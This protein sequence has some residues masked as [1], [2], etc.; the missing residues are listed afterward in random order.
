MGI[1]QKVQQGI[2]VGLGNSTTP[3]GSE[4]I[5]SSKTL[6]MDVHFRIIHNRQKVQQHNVHQLYI[7][8]MWSIHKIQYYSAIKRNEALT[9]ATP[10]INPEA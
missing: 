1:P 6:Q 4:N 3:N 7:D 5:Y 10:L 8:K 9:R 2:K